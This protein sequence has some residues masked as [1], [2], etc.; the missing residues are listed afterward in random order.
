M[1]TNFYCDAVAVVVINQL[2]MKPIKE[3]HAYMCRHLSSKIF[4][5]NYSSYGGKVDISSFYLSLPV[6]YTSYCKY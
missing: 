4:I 1:L 5:R 2:Q 6:Q 3:R